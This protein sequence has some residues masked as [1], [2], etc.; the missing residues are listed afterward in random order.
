M[1][2]ELGKD[3]VFHQFYSTYTENNY[4]GFG[5]SKI[6]GH[7]ILI[8]K[9]NDDIMLLAMEETVLQGMTDRLTEAE[10]CQG[11]E[12]NVGRLKQ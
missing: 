4:E 9:Q 3:A 12:V 8:V 10:I 11:M 6:G 7:I 5:D 1:E 2:G